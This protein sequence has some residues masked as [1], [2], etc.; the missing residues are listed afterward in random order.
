[1]LVRHSILKNHTKIVNGSVNVLI[2]SDGATLA[3]MVTAMNSIALN[4]HAH[5]KFYLVVDKDSL[6]HLRC[7][8]FT[9]SS[10]FHNNY[11][12]CPKKAERSIFITLI[13]KNIA[14]FNFIRLHVVF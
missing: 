1:M 11:T 8:N 10:I 2:C 12:G 5:V 4:T 6:D 7:A 9:N 13:L 14:Y 3:G